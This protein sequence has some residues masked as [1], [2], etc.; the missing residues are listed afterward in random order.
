[1]LEFSQDCD[2]LVFMELAFMRS[3]NDC[4]RSNAENE[5]YADRDEPIAV[6]EIEHNFNLYVII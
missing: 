5:D 3:V 2:F 6:K 4:T 1:M